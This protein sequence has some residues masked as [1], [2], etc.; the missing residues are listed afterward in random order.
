MKLLLSVCTCLVLAGCS[1][2]SVGQTTAK[3][4]GEAFYMERMAVPPDARL[5]VV[6][7]DIS[8]ADAPAE[9]I[10]SVSIQE[11]G[12]PPYP[13]TIEYDPEQIDPRHTYRLAARLYDGEKLL[14]RTD[15]VHQ[16]ITRGFPSEAT[17]RMR[18]V[19]RDSTPSSMEQLPATFMGSF[20]ATYT[21]TLPC[22]DCLRSVVHLNLL[23]AGAYVLREA[24]QGSDSA[25]SFD[26]GRYL[27][28][29]DGKQLTLHGGR[30]APRA[31]ER[32]GHNELRISLVDTKGQR[33]EAGPE[34]SLIRQ[35]DFMPLEPQLLLGGEYRYMAGAGRFK[36][37]L[38]GLD[39]P[40]AS[41]GDNRA[42]EEAYL[43]AQQEPGDAM[44]V[45][46][47]GR[48][49][50]RMPVEGDKPVR[51]LIPERFIGVSPDSSCPPVIQRAAF[52]NT[53][54]RLTLLGSEGV[55][56]VDNQ[57]EPHLVFNQNGRVSGA[58]G[59]NN[60]TGTY[61]R[62]NASLRFSQLVTTRKACM[63]G[64]QQA[65]AFLDTL[66][67]I[68]SYQV[69]GEHLEMRDASGQLQLRFE[70]VVF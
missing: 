4:S 36:E 61:T 54:W 2:L 42:L 20:P 52:K 27:L 32:I 65:H 63:E 57:R 24:Y 34:D 5:D 66:T 21:D 25:P 12:Q 67:T 1:A 11:A 10:A 59:C 50:E 47:E 48:L 35:T 15:E 49:V 29:S 46:L 30:E 45:S 70:S 7:E 58:D 22:E 18:R 51:T 62:D 17:L 68:T 23:P 26:I 38:T 53:Y 16:V 64:M 43:A 55:Q 9:K 8:R 44:K 60:L 14:F 13:F 28:S 56:R 6:L 39:M 19:A 31:F 41:E 40:V 3:V 33:I 69:V 37:C